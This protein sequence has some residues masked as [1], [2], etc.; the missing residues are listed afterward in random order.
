MPAARLSSPISVSCGDLSR[1]AQDVLSLV[2]IWSRFRFTCVDFI[3]S[4]W[5]LHDKMST[6]PLPELSVSIIKLVVRASLSIFLRYD[7]NFCIQVY[8][9]PYIYVWSIRPVIYIAHHFPILQLLLTVHCSSPSS[10]SA[11]K[12]LVNDVLRDEGV[13]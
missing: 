12:L 9:S 11:H 13:R 4:T 8:V 5:F 10:I 2:A 1:S 3:I 6:I 7:F